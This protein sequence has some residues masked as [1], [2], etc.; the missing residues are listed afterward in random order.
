MTHR[1]L[2]HV[3][4]LL[5][6]GHLRRA[7]ILACAMADGGLD[8][9]VAL[10]G[11]PLPEVP[12]EGVR[13]SRLPTAAIANEDFSA[14]LDEQDRPVD[15]G[16]RERRRAALLDCYRATKPHVV[17]IELYPFGRRQF[18]F[19]L[20][21]LL[22]LAQTQADRPAIACS[23]RD[24]LVASRKSGRD[25][26]IVATLRRSFD[27]VLVH[28]DPTLIPF[29]ETFP[30]ADQIADLIRH[31][32]YA[33]ATSL[34]GAPADAIGEVIVSAGGG[35]VGAPL[36]YAAAGA[37][38]KSALRD[39]PWRFLTGPN[40]PEEDFQRL[41]TQVGEGAIVERFRQDFAA[42]LQG[43]ALSI[44]QAGYNTT[45]DILA[46]GVR[47][48]VVPYET[49]SETEQRLRAE[50]LAAKGVLTLVPARE[51]TADRLASAI[52][53][54]TRR[55]PPSAS[56]DLNGAAATAGIVRALAS[57]RRRAVR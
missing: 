43:A 3:Q 50:I 32:G 18:R 15:A 8:V 9:T 45:M 21:P 1:V 55:S 28:G 41:A 27:A 11:R 44:S 30:A 12:F 6:I 42:R 10:G 46:S 4:H 14:L 35:A 54:A 49:A 34:A 26:E 38:T 57:E 23:V 25:A 56:V 16:W 19:E 53:D 48:I 31:T 40:L 47:A 51:L 7:E 20:D 36:L 24:V 29:S 22:E 2:F 17:L 37:R 39:R 33:A 52:A 13:I 5:G